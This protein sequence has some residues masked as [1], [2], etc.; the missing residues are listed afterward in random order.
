MAQFGGVLFRGFDVIKSPVEFND[1]V[2]SLGVDPLPYVGGA[3]PRKVVHKGVFTSNESPPSEKIPFHHE[4]AQVPKY[5]SKIFF[6]CDI[7][8]S[9]GG[10]TPVLR[11][12]ELYVRLKDKYPEFIEQLQEKGLKYT[13]ILPPVDDHNS[14][15]GR[16]WSSTFGTDDPNE[17]RKVAAGLGV[18]LDW[19]Q[20]GNVKSVSG[21]LK[22][23]KSFTNDYGKQRTVFFNSMIAA[24]TGWKDCRNEPESAVTLGDGT[25]LDPSIIEGIK[26]VMEEIAVVFNWEKGD[27]LCLDNNIVMH[28]RQTF[29]PPRR[30]LAYVAI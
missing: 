8:S 12:D 22:G 1:L 3:A 24:Y 28:A 4:M 27:V 18:T 19:Q 29:V 7:P 14:P 17:A 15:I 21:V 11:S 30:T 5:P 20:D 23:V 10:A 6:Y 26:G 9:S 2:E 13:R 25:R 16:S